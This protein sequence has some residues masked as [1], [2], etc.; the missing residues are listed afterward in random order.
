MPD[1]SRQ[2]ITLIWLWRHSTLCFI[3]Y[4]LGKF[5]LRTP[6]LTTCYLL[7]D[8][9]FSYAF[10][11]LC[12]NKVPQCGIPLRKQSVTSNSL[13]SNSHIKTY[14]LPQDLT[15]CEGTANWQIK[16]C[17]LKIIYGNHLY[18]WRN[19]LSTKKYLLHSRHTGKKKAQ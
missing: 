13:I 8:T 7:P 6:F 2:L 4:S 18:C 15:L 12:L 19:Q 17:Q 16:L 1:K 14:S 9:N 11:I 5:I 10:G 3:Y